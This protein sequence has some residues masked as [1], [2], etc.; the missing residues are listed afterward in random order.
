MDFT[1]EVINSKALS[2]AFSDSSTFSFA[3]CLLL[4]GVPLSCCSSPRWQHFG[5]LLHLGQGGCSRLTF[6]KSL[7]DFMP[8]IHVLWYLDR[9][10]VECVSIDA[11]IVLHES[12]TM[13]TKIAMSDTR[14][15]VA[16]LAVSQIRQKWLSSAVGG[17]LQHAM[18]MRYMWDTNQMEDGVAGA[19][20][21]TQEHWLLRGLPLWVWDSDQDHQVQKKVHAAEA[22]DGEQGTETQK[23]EG[24]P[25]SPFDASPDDVPKDQP[26]KKA[27]TAGAEFNPPSCSGFQPSRGTFASR[28]GGR[29]VARSLCAELPNAASPKKK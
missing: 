29:S 14:T 26:K 12:P 19:H 15:K 5:S 18:V 20:W 21:D 27:K 24:T 13:A 7:G 22:T 1:P 28:S 23:G 8:L 2:S 6:I 4:E 16:F 11:V 3:F 17:P 25:G 10:L 9:Y